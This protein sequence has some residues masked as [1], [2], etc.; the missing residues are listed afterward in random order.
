MSNSPTLR[1]P[2]ILVI[3]EFS[4][5]KREVSYFSMKFDQP[6]DGDGQVA[7]IPRG[8]KITMRLKALN[9]GNPDLVCWM[10]DKKKTYSGSIEFLNTIDGKLM[11]TYNFTDAY[12]VDYH[13]QWED[14]SGL[15]ADAQYLTHWEQIT[16]SCR[17]ITDGGAMNF[18]NSWELVE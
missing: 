14:P 15:K 16:I 2:V 13:E 12:C 1:N 11:K 6:T 10:I 9:Q 4:A 3:K 18:K 5:P 7:A 17:T 8:G